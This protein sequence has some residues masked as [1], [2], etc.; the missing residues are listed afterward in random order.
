[1]TTCAAP[2]S[3]FSRT[4]KLLSIYLSSNL[5]QVY[6]ILC[7]SL[8]LHGVHCSACLAVLSLFLLSVCRT[9]FSLLLFNWSTIGS[10]S[11]WP[12]YVYVC[13]CTMLCKLHL[14]SKEQACAYRSASV[15]VCKEC[16]VRPQIQLQ[17]RVTVRTVMP[18]MSHYAENVSP[19]TGKCLF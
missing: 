16:V 14:V 11:V 2:L 4:W 3:F 15:C 10:W 18:M 1:M 9:Q 7:F 19:G 8:W 13:H 6:L 5:F 12:A 17:R